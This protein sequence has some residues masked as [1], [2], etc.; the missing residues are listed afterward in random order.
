MRRR[1]ITPAFPAYR[2]S[3]PAPDPLA[4]GP[5]RWLQRAD[6]TVVIL[7]HEAPVTLLR[8]QRAQRFLDRAAAA[9][10]AGLQQLMARSTGNF[11][12]G[13]ERDAKRHGRQGRP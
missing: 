11:K 9:D 8:G 1:P 7:Y 13:N 5:F 4:D 3:V 12:R 6:G 10:D 2:S